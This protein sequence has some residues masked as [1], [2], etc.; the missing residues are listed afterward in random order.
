MEKE[1]TMIEQE[2]QKETNDL[3]EEAKKELGVYYYHE[4]S[5]LID[6]L[7]KEIAKLRIKIREIN[8]LINED[9]RK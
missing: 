1:K 5:D 6:F 2:I 8:I 9:D 7:F 3:I 4:E